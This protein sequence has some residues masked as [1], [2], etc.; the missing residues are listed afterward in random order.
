MKPNSQHAERLRELAKGSK[1]KSRRKE[2]HALAYFKAGY[3]DLAKSFQETA[4][5]HMS[6]S[7]ALLA[8]AEALEREIW[9]PI[10]TAPKNGQGFLAWNESLRSVE[11][12]WWRD[13]MAGITHWRPIP[14]GPIHI[15]ALARLE[16]K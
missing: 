15:A 11:V 16:G 9:Q 8:G 5:G 7:A 3:V 6:E 4:Q 13:N 12:T 1:E 14:D 10:E 2:K